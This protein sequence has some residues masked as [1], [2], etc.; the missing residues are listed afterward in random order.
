MKVFLANTSLL[1]SYGG[2]AYSV[3]RLALALAEAGVEVGIWAPDQSAA[4]TPLLSAAAPV[5]RLTGSEVE[6]LRSFGKPDVLHDNGIWWRHHHALAKLAAQRRI[7][8]IVSTRG[9]LEP[10]AVDH[11]KW[12]K[13]LGWWLYQRRD[14]KRAL[15]HHTTAQAEADH[16][17]S[18]GLGVRVCV[19]PNGVD[20]PALAQGASGVGER[21]TG[22]EAQKTALFVGRIYPVKGLP[23][24]V[25]AWARVR[26]GGWRLQIV[27]P[28]E[29]GHRAEV[30]KAVS[31]AGLGDVISF[32][33]PAHGEAKR[34]L[35]LNA[36]LFVLPTHS[37][38]FGMAIGEALAHG[39][40]VLTTSAAPWPML[41]ERGCGWSVDATVEGIVQGLREA[42]SLD[43][44]TLQA[45]GAKGRAFVEAEFAWKRVAG[46][47]VALYEEV[48]RNPSAHRHV[49][50]KS[51]KP[52]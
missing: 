40:P 27:G 46:E 30:E 2:P 35:F 37:E 45:M 44:T 31:A 19:I 11:K 22:K 15:A 38:N 18:M 1:P 34:L 41:P 24:L 21:D 50:E 4:T 13:C 12:K 32:L 29:A 6:A 20:I 3:S 43:S 5:Q 51:R 33:G 10:W 23:M 14:L 52:E 26:P 25:E 9:M 16:V 36:D 39:L 49:S 48:K 28:D 17:Q 47:F 7:P 8:R 42:T